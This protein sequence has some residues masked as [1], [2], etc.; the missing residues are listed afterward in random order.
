MSEAT[1]G[2]RDGLLER[3]I[4]WCA[5]NRIAVVLSVGIVALAAAASLRFLAL[6]AIP[7]LS[8]TQVIVRAE[9]MGRSPDLVEDQVTYP[10]VS[11]LVAMPRAKAVRGYSMYGMSFVYVLFDDGTDIYWARSRVL[12]YL[13]RIQGNMPDGVNPTLG[14]DATGVGWVFQYALVDETGKMDL[15]GI[16]AFQDW[17]LRYWLE[18]VE[19]VAEV[20]SVGG[21]QRQYQVLVDPHQVHARG[22][23]LHDVAKAVG[24]SNAEVGGRVIERGGREIAV[25]GRGYVRGVEDIEAAVVGTDGM[26]TPVL[27]RDVAMVRVGPEM[28]RGA[29]DLDGEGETV[30]G[31]VVMRHGENALAVIERVKKRI[32]EV[33]KG[34]PPGLRLKVVYDR[35]DVILG[36][37]DTLKETIIEEML[38]VSAVIIVFLMHFRSALVPIIALPVALLLAFLP[39]ALLGISSNIM[40]LGGI[41]ISIG[42]MTDVSIVLLDNAHKR[43]EQR[44]PGV[45]RVAAIAAAAAEVGRPIFFGQLMITVSFLPVFTLTGQAGR[46]FSPLAYTKTFALF[47]SAIL[48]VTLAPALVVW[49]VRGRITPEA[50]N[51]ISRVLIAGYGPLIHFVLR[52]RYAAVLA[53][54]GIMAAT[55]PLVPRLGSEFMPPLDEGS[56]MY[57]PTTLPGVSIEE[58]RRSM[59]EQDRILKSFPEVVSVYGKVGRSTTSTDPAPLDM[60]ETVITLKPRDQW[61]RVK[62][63]RWYS[64]WAP[65]FLAGP[66]GGIWPEERPITTEELKQLMYDALNVPGWVDSL[67]PPIKTRIDMLTTGVR[68]PVGIKVLGSSL[69][70]ISRVAEH[71]EAILKTVDGTRGVIAERVSSGYYLDIVPKRAEIARH[72]LSVEDVHALVEM[73][74]GGMRVGTTVEGRGRFSILVRLAQDF[75]SDPAAIAD[76]PVGRPNAPPI[77]LGQIADIRVT[78]GPPMIKS[79]NGSLAA[80]VYVDVDETRRDVGGYVADAKR[81][82]RENLGDHPG[83]SLLWT[84]QYEL[85]EQMWDRLAYVLPLTFVLIVAFVYLSFKGVTQTVLKLASLPFAAVGAI[86]FLYLADYRMSTAVFVGLIALMG[87]GA[88]TGMVMIQYIDD[89][90]FHRRKAGLMRGVPDIMEAHAEGSIRRV[91]PKLMTVLPTTI[92]LLPLLWS[93]GTGADVMKRIAAPMVGGL[94]SSTILTLVIIPSVYTIWRDLELRNLWRRT[95]F[96]LACLAVAGGLVAL[97]LLSPWWRGNIPAPWLVS[98]AGATVLVAAG[99]FVRARVVGRR[100]LDDP[101]RLD[102]PPDASTDPAAAGT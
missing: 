48:T 30:G 13:S 9:W 93:Q 67:S 80:Y 42:A 39:M 22:M 99:V 64:S 95:A 7:D 17:T 41:A 94:L 97:A 23:M 79:E 89:A 44:P 47:F 76:I 86:W 68:T 57:M 28:R 81:A 21:F 49:F 87:L 45:S 71:L 12:E 35:S 73:A 85:M 25:R 101:L 59:I 53:A 26:G 34:F 32:A 70:E 60:I 14:P 96:M 37:I 82:V 3:L 74:I 84:G 91:R 36:S 38:V 50:R 18:S 75:R 72:G 15:G 62:E 6:D 55:A 52:H 58:A 63:E 33:E 11:A 77:P 43:L 66:L 1:T 92:G 10:I 65:N 40:S 31:I 102:A 69:E 61:R 100:W 2:R 54:I 78:D 29:G 90:Y 51:P 88:E 46:L 16:R 24:G 5:H 83:I 8:D 98:V 20:A 19:G 56:L 4:L 27:V